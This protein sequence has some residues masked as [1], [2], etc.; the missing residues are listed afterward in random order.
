MLEK[1]ETKNKPK[2]FRVTRRVT[3]RMVTDIIQCSSP[4]TAVIFTDNLTD[5]EGLLRQITRDGPIMGVEYD[6]LSGAIVEDISDS[7]DYYE[8]DE[9]DLKDLKKSFGIKNDR[10][11]K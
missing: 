4:V 5:Y 9:E 7:G 6:E 8:F 11:I 2:K 1:N 10:S 3:V